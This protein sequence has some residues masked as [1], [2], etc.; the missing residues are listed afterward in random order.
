MI[1]ARFRVHV[2]T[3]RQEVLLPKTSCSGEGKGKIV[4]LKEKQGLAALG[5]L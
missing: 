5:I 1:T 4:N 2:A 3:A